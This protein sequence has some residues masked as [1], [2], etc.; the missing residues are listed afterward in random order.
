KS[1]TPAKFTKQAPLVLAKLDKDLDKAERP[2]TKLD[3]RVAKS[4]VADPL[5]ATPACGRLGFEWSV[6]SADVPTL[7]PAE[8]DP[9]AP[10]ADDVPAPGVL[11]PG[12]YR[13]SPEIAALAARTTMT[14][15]GRQY[16]YAA[17]PQVLTGQPFASSCPS[18]EASTQQILGCYRDHKI[19]V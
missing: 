15:L 11:L 18:A 5:R 7:P 10:G 1:S 14:G 3:R 2:I 12:N 4:S 17:G 16:F 19:F 13:P 6:I 9:A 8:I